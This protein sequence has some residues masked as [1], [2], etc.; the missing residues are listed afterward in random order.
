MKYVTVSGENHADALKKL[1]EQY[2]IEAIIYDER[3]IKDKTIMGKMLKKEK[4]EIHAALTEKKSSIHSVKDKMEGLHSLLNKTKSEVKDDFHDGK[5]FLKKININ[6][7]DFAENNDI[8]EKKLLSYPVSIEKD[9]KEER[10]FRNIDSDNSINKLYLE[11]AEIKQN[12]KDLLLNKTAGVNK[13]FNEIY[14]YLLDHDFSEEWSREIIEDLK[15]SLPLNEWKMKKSIS[16]K[17]KE[18]F[19]KRIK[20]NPILGSKRIIT[21]LG[22]TGVGKT[23]TVAKLAARL[24]LKENKSVS[25]ITLDNYRIAAT[26]Q[27][28]LYGSIMDI[29]VHVCKE[30]EKFDQIIDEEKNEIIIVDTTGMSQ[31]NKEFLLRQKEFFKNKEHEIE[32]HLM[33]AA[34]VKTKDMIDIFESFSIFNID[35]LIVAKEDETNSLG[36]IIEMAEKW[37]LPFSFVMT[38]QRVPDDYMPASKEYIADKIM[39]LWDK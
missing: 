30:P 32:K 8:I 33:V 10:S 27:L 7:S 39:Y 6:R 26:E 22:P 25:L 38:G 13:E 31:N 28:K 2:G 1:R 35:K 3:K 5:N 16:E 11:L 18:I 37:N 15:Q 12:M 4:W 21:L 19:K 29:K 14:Q 17:I 9:L 20:I 23:T 34:N 24:K 36:Y